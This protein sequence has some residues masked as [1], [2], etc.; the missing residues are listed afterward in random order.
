MD[1]LFLIGA[2]II[3]L[4]SKSDIFHL[5]IRHQFAMIPHK[6]PPPLKAADRFRMGIYTT[7]GGYA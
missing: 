6:A 1:L 7:S 2:N 3:L 4:L 5:C